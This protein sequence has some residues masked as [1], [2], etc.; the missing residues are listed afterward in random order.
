MRPSPTR[1]GSERSEE[2]R[3]G[4]TNS[5]CIY[6][7]DVADIINMI[8]L[9]AGVIAILIGIIILAYAKKTDFQIAETKFWDPLA[10]L[11][12]KLGFYDKGIFEAK[13]YIQGSMSILIGVGLI[14]LDLLGKLR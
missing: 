12:K 4:Q 3:R 10:P 9:I 13:N 14:V 11:T 5:Y 6:I 2:V 8:G 7:Q 1:R